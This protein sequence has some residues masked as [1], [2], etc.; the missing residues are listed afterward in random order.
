[1]TILY[2]QHNILKLADIY[3]LE[4]A[5][6]MHQLHNNKLPFFL[7]EDYVELNEIH[8]HN[9]RQTQNAVYFNPR[10][11]KSIGKELLVYKGA[12]L[13]ENV[14]G[15]TKSFSWYSF[16]KRFKRRLISNYVEI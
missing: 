1:M 10:V 2:Q 13:W 9:T 11:K 3:G 6:Y 16:K 14:D 4:L 8:S 5:K 7:Y 15:S 12:K